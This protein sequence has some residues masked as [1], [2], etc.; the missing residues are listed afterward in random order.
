MVN[1]FADKVD[2]HVQFDFGGDA[3]IDLMGVKSLNQLEDSLH[4]F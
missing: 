4:L 2:G 3:T 1:R